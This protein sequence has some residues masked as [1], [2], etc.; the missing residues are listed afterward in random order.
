[1]LWL[2]VFI[3]MMRRLPVST[4]LPF[5][6]LSGSSVVRPSLK[7][8]VPLGLTTAALPGELTLTVAVKVTDWPETEGLAEET[9]VVVVAAL[10][11]RKSGVEGEGVDLGGRRFIA[12]KM[13][14][15]VVRLLMVK[16]E[17]V[18]PPL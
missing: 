12:E 3:V 6:T 2:A 16:V 9:T 15:A 17:D 1:M 14:L 13:W 10:L 4:P 18:T 8:T 11:D 7:V 5:A